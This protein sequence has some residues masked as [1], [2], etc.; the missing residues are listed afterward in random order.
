MPQEITIHLE[1][2][3]PHRFDDVSS[4][5]GPKDYGIYQVYG[6][7]PIYGNTALLYIGLAA[8]QHFGERVPQETWWADNRD[9]GRVEIYVGRLSGSKTPDDDTWDQQIRLA[10]RLLIYAHSPPI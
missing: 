3:G 5:N 2:Y 8:A 6:G 7:H 10:E 9:A 4:L 1:W